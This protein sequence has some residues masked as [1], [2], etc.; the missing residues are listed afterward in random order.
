MD[1]GEPQEFECPLCV[2]D[3]YE[4]VILYRSDGSPYEQNFYK[5]SRCEFH[6][7][8]PSAFTKPAARKSSGRDW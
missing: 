4:A 2:S 8:E 1:T 5:C 7:L 6:F 3:K